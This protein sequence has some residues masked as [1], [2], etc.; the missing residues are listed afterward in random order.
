MLARSNDDDDETCKTL[1][2]VIE[3]LHEPNCP[4]VDAASRNLGAPTI[5]DARRRN[6]NDHLLLQCHQRS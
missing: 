6:Y 2:V 1:R 5:P 4:D 3:L